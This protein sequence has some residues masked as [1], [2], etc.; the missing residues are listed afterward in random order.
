MTRSFSDSSGTHT[1]EWVFISYLYFNSL[2][3]FYPGYSST[4]SLTVYHSL[5]WYELRE[6]VTGHQKRRK[7]Y[8]AIQP[9]LSNRKKWSHCFLAQVPGIHLISNILWFVPDFLAAKL[10]S[11]MTSLDRKAT[12]VVH[13]YKM[14]WLNTKVTNLA[15]YDLHSTCCSLSPSSADL[16]R[17]VCTPKFCVFERGDSNMNLKLWF[18]WYPCT[19]DSWLSC[20]CNFLFVE[21]FTEYHYLESASMDSAIKISLNLIAWLHAFVFIPAEK[22]NR[23]LWK[24]MRGWFRWSHISRKVEPT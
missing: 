13:A 4:H 22:F 23:W 17:F 10:P 7:K 18:A 11:M 20:Y 16:S 2:F 15:K 9:R 14:Q 8:E 12:T 1:N 3:E 19:D 24:R 21:F 6:A 5:S